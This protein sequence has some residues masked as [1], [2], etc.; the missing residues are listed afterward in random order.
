MRIESLNLSMHIQFMILFF[1]LWYS[2]I[3]YRMEKFK[4]A[5]SLWSNTSATSKA[6]KGQLWKFEL[7]DTSATS[8]A[9]MAKWWNFELLA[10]SLVWHPIIVWSLCQPVTQY[11]PGT[12]LYCALHSGGSDTATTQ[13]HSQCCGWNN[14]ETPGHHVTEADTINMVPCSGPYQQLFS[15]LGWILICSWLELNISFQ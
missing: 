14:F 7:C 3:I 13:Q 11:N 15:C 9:S 10:E 2:M 6:S 8:K 1:L 12:K 5:E 4:S